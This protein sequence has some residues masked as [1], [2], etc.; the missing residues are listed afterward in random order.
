MPLPRRK[1]YDK[2]RVLAL[3]SQRRH[4]SGPEFEKLDQNLFRRACGAFATG[5]TVATVLGRDAKPHGLTANSFSSVSL[6]PP[7]VLIC[8]AHQAA[9]HG[10][11]SSAS[12]F[13]I[14]IL[15][16]SQKDLSVRFASS[17]PNRFEGL[18]WTLGVV[19]APILLESLAVIECEMREKIAAGDHTIFLGE[20]RKVVVREGK[21]LLYHAGKYLEIG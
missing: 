15:G 2:I 14:N 13:A 17:H 1:A 12:S 8:V 19:G 21:P 4:T 11:F 20:V 18:E 7:L 9:T 6:D 5:I 10:P 3:S 16:E